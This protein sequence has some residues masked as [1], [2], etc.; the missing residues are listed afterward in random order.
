MLRNH[1]QQAI[2]SLKGLAYTCEFATSLEEQLKDQ[3]VCGIINQELR[4]K[5]L[6]ASSDEGLTWA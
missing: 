6:N 2:A 5:L 1:R 4:Q 3:F